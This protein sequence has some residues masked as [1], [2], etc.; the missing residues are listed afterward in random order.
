MTTHEGDKLRRDL[1]DHGRARGKRVDP[2]LRGRIVAFAERRR[3]DGA[4][5]M[6]IATELDACFETIRRWCGGG[7]VGVPRKLRRVEVM[8]EP[9]PAVPARAPLTVVTPSGVRVE[10]V[11]IDDVVALVR[12]LG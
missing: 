6:T 12:A 9:I 10:G 11:A 5:W 1:R 8:A 2:E 3:R 4:S 7:S